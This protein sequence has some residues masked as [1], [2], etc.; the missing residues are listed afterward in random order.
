MK[1]IIFPL[2]II[3]L[4]LIN[5]TSCNLF[6][7]KGSG[8]PVSEERSIIEFDEIELDGSASV[9]LEQ[10]AKTKLTVVVDSNLQQYVI[11]KVSGMKLEV[12]E[13]KC[14][15]ELT[16]YEIHITTPALTKL[17][18]SGSVKVK[19]DKIIKTDNLYIKVKSSGDVSLGVDTEDL[20][21]IAKGSGN[22]QLFGRAADFDINLDGA[23]AIDAF[24]L[25]AKNVD[26]DVDGAGTC[27]INVSEKFKG[28]V[29]GSGK[30]YYKGN[31]KK[32]QT[33]I[34]GTGS[35]KAK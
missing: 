16:R 31:P 33:D 11:T 27:K 35:I 8:N 19:G 6:C 30:I 28:D 25:I 17:Y 26:A 18:V 20:E 22:I 15:K 21:T 23:G 13:D 12:Y 24:A 10:G 1:N 32:V 14:L 34:S 3:S 5:F 29:G 2:T 9:F 4:L 7:E